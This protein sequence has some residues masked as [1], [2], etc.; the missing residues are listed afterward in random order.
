MPGEAEGK[1]VP[2]LQRRAAGW[3]WG[4]GVTP[5]V[6][7]EDTWRLLHWQLASSVCTAGNPSV[8]SRGVFTMVKTKA[9]PRGLCTISHPSTCPWV[10][11]P[12]LSPVFIL[13]DLHHGSDQRSALQV[14][15]TTKPSPANPS[16]CPP[17]ANPAFHVVGSTVNPAAPPQAF[18]PRLT[19]VNRSPPSSPVMMLGTG[20][21]LLIA[22][23]G[24][25]PAQPQLLT[26]LLHPT[27]TH[28]HT[29]D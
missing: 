29:K 6:T 10:F 8:C 13:T 2:L 26:G 9:H 5:R 28:N 22:D 16:L 11:A 1:H 21:G 20:S 23:L 19:P 17:A 14:C 3:H 4:P 15:S 24:H 7:L 18:A 25:S 12:R 27:A